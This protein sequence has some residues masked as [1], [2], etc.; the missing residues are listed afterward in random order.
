MN[1]RVPSSISAELHLVHL[2]GR[3]RFLLATAGDPVT[4]DVAPDA[5]LKVPLASLVGW[6]GALTPRVCALVED[7]GAPVVVAVE[8]TGEGRVIAD[9]SATEG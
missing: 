9:P 1:G 2:R 4:V 7:G 3:G 6:V 8:L 5:P